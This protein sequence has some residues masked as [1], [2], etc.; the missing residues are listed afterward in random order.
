MYF[1]YILSNW[2]HRVLYIGVTSELKRRIYEHKNGLH[3]GF[4]KRYHVHK[5]LYY[6]KFGDVHRAISREKQLKT[7]S[8]EK[9]NELINRINPE[10][11]DISE[12]F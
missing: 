7:W 12:Y 8:R 3:D 10:W 11:L 4:T 5:L 6:E 9:K 2:N 1:V